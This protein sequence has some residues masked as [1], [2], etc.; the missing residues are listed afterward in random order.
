MK[1]SHLFTVST[2]RIDHSVKYKISSRRSGPSEQAHFQDVRVFFNLSRMSHCKHLRERF[3]ETSKK[4]KDF[5]NYEMFDSQEI[6]SRN[7]VN[8]GDDL[9]FIT[10]SELRPMQHFFVNT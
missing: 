8:I 6:Y 5:H 7:Q 3:R 2:E 9:T 10:H 4:V 1:K